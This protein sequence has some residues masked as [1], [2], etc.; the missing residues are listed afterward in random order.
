MAAFSFKRWKNVLLLTVFLT[1]CYFVGIVLATFSQVKFNI[2]NIKFLILIIILLLAII[3]AFD[4]K[5]K[6]LKVKKE[7]FI[8]VLTGLF[9]FFNGIGCSI[10]FIHEIEILDIK[11]IPV[12]QVLLGFSASIITVVLA[13]ITINTI[14]QKFVKVGTL[15]LNTS[16]SVVVICITLSIMVKQILY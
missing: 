8:L 2:P 15:K 6:Y 16:I 1:T 7:H 5:N 11:F 10:N 14:F 3:K 4:F 12:I 9:G 13:V